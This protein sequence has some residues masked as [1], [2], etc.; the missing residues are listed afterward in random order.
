MNR[1]ELFG[2]TVAALAARKLPAVKEPQPVYVSTFRP[3]PAAPR[4]WPAYI[5]SMT[6]PVTADLG[7]SPD[8]DLDDDARPSM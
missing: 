1:R 4:V 8:C 2:L 6:I 5:W 7:P 3:L